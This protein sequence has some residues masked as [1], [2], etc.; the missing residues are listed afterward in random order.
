V[1]AAFNPALIEGLGR[2]PRG[3]G[4]GGAPGVQ[5]LNVPWNGHA[6][7]SPSCK[8]GWFRCA[9]WAAEAQVKPGVPPSVRPNAIVEGSTLD[10]QKLLLNIQ[11]VAGAAP[12]Q[13]FTYESHLYKYVFTGYDTKTGKYGSGQNNIY[14]CMDGLTTLKNPDQSV[15]EYLL[16]PSGENEVLTV[17]TPPRREAE[18]FYRSPASLI[19]KE[20][21][22]ETAFNVRGL[23][24]VAQ[25]RAFNPSLLRGLGRSPTGVGQLTPGAN[26]TPFLTARS[27][28]YATVNSSDWVEFY[29]NDPKSFRPNTNL[30]LNATEQ[31]SSGGPGAFYKANP[32]GNAIVAQISSETLGQSGYQYWTLT[33]PNNRAAYTVG[34]FQGDVSGDGASSA[35]AFLRSSW[36]NGSKGGP[37]IEIATKTAA[38]SPDQLKSW[39]TSAV[40]V[41][42]TLIPSSSSWLQVAGI[43]GGNLAASRGMKVALAGSDLSNVAG[44]YYGSYLAQ[45]QFLTGIPS[46]QWGSWWNVGFGGVPLPVASSVPTIYFTYGGQLYRIYWQGPWVPVSGVLPPPSSQANVV[47]DICT[48]PP[49]SILHPPTPPAPPTL[50]PGRILSPIQLLT[51]PSTA[52]VP[53]VVA[54]SGPPPAPIAYPPSPAP[55][56]TAPTTTSSPLLILGAIVGIAVLGGVGYLVL[57]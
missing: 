3:L 2:V 25:D 29:P 20:P 21:S 15:S 1:Q 54:P 40:I 38:L 16:V 41:N 55:P 42:N 33:D 36:P 10:F 44:T 23:G 46:P 11:S 37:K 9:T 45:P 35:T 31:S 18:K 24:R 4:N 50:Q 28:T 57:E 53:P 52:P 32:I 56:V 26:G 47:V 27:S 39:P 43:V 49:V 7:V 14:V 17:H 6:P 5:F 22:M 13:F 34:P 51:P 8:T 48:N 19:S 12:I 30:A